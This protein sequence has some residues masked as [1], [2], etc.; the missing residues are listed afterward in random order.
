M[1]C[2]ACREE[3]IVVEYRK[4]EVDICMF[5]RGIW[6]DA[7]ELELLL[8]TLHLPPE[9]LFRKPDAKLEEAARK[10]PYCRR[11]MEKVLAGPGKG[12][13]IDR[14]GRG[15]G[16]WFDGGELDAVVRG[17]QESAAAGKPPHE[18]SRKIGSFLADVLYQV[19]NPAQRTP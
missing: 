16:L 12:E 8:G 11:K 7:N 2:P 14:C 19:V 10:C 3:M 5:C 18:A 1:I 4:I 15:H 6:F 13:V 17:L 9:H